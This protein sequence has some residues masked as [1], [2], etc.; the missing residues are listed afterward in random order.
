MAKY[1]FNKTNLILIVVII[2]ISFGA[3][4]QYMFYVISKNDFNR[5]LKNSQSE[6]ESTKKI[7]IENIQ[8]PKLVDPVRE[9]DY[10]KVND[11]LEEPTRRVA[12]HEIP[13]VYLKRLI[14]IPSR[15]YPDNFIQIGV[16][17]IDDKYKNKDTK[18]NKIIRLFGRQ[19]Y[20][21]SNR[22]E[23]YT[24]INSGLDSIKVGLDTRKR[25]LYDGDTVFV[26][27]LNSKYTVNLHKF[28]APKYYPD[29]F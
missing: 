21:G 27:E 29:L 12:R 2:I 16:L 28:D 10:K 24:S 1:C 23:Y 11:I 8:K 17:V 19:E 26:K 22:Y 20:P 15:G 25:E 6:T 4:I 13:P 14:D 18:D 9:Y 5:E 3:M 7:V